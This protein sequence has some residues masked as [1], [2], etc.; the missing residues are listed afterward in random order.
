MAWYTLLFVA[1]IVLTA[2]AI[3][4]QE[5]RLEYTSSGI[6]VAV[7][8]CINYIL[9]EGTSK[10][11]QSLIELSQTSQYHLLTNLLDPIIN[12]LQ[13]NAISARRVNISIPVCSR[14]HTTNCLTRGRSYVMLYANK[15]E[16]FTY[17]LPQEPFL[18]QQHD[19]SFH[20]EFMTVAFAKDDLLPEFINFTVT[21]CEVSH[22]SLPEPSCPLMYNLEKCRK[23]LYKFDRTVINITVGG[24]RPWSWH[25]TTVT[26]SNSIFD[27]TISFTGMTQ[28]HPFTMSPSVLLMLQRQTHLVY[29]FRA[30][31]EDVP[32]RGVPETFRVSLT[33]EFGDVVFNNERF[34]VMERLG[35]D[36]TGVERFAVV[37]TNPEIVFTVRIAQLPSY[38]CFSG[39]FRMD[40][41]AVGVGPA[42]HVTRLCT[43]FGPPPKPE[44]PIITEVRNNIGDEEIYLFVTW[45]TF[46]QPQ[47]FISG[48][49]LIANVDEE[50][51][52]LGKIVA[53]TGP[54]ET[55]TLIL[56][57]GV[58]ATSTLD[59]FNLRLRAF[60]SEGISAL[61][62][63]AVDPNDIFAST[64]GFSMDDTTSG[65]SIISVVLAPS[66]IAIICILLGVVMV[67]LNRHNQRRVLQLDLPAIDSWE[68]TR[69]D[70]MIGSNI[71]TDVFGNVYD[72]A[73]CKTDTPSV[74]I[75][76][77]CCNQTS[78]VIMKRKFLEEAKMLKSLA[79]DCH[80]N[81]VNLMGCCLQD[82]PLM[83]L[84]QQTS[85]GNL[86]RLLHQFSPLL[87]DRTLSLKERLHMMSD[88][89]SGMKYLHDRSIV[90]KD[91]AAR[92]CFVTDSGS[93]KLAGFGNRY[94]SLDVALLPV[95]WMA[96][97]IFL[98]MKFT[99]S[100]DVW[101][102]GI[103]AW[104]I[105]TYGRLPY[106]TLSNEQVCA[107]VVRGERLEQPPETPNIIYEMMLQCWSS[108]RPSIKYIEQFLKEGLARSELSDFNS[109]KSV[110][111]Q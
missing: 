44:P 79:S 50:K 73:L 67:W 106:T 41:G 99:F 97:E 94:D 8:P 90:H 86:R 68:C 75:I 84:V 16:A 109:S 78:E 36:D 7:D 70:I 61:S 100:T 108:E 14:V 12:E 66:I 57:S 74:G 19:L 104:E 77:R 9:A 47:T 69:D 110:T 40:F 95:R 80:P 25:C 5:A 42:V 39:E 52:E 11:S 64:I 81:I 1:G 48:F 102:F 101:A 58:N 29:R 96:P 32:W 22:G 103:T 24:L 34:P 33:S 37:P 93:I 60:N 10:L 88:I 17:T 71:G 59:R 89:S 62:D 72:G 56:L 82:E 76:V 43:D 13:T 23:S 20:A 49:Q 53:E 91:L 65:S 111:D 51:R 45:S 63:I 107:Y 4:L 15:T 105:E 30:R 92:N 26:Y 83:L 35:A 21:V 55:S 87:T 85:L 31:A 6:F 38:T 28:Q 54:T 46:Q 18:P 27:T 98:E 3:C 2:K